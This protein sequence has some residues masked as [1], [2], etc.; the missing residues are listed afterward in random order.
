MGQLHYYQSA[1]HTYIEANTS[2]ATAGP[3]L[4]IVLDH[5]IAMTGGDFLL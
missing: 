4:V 3:E 5:S 2:D 1:G